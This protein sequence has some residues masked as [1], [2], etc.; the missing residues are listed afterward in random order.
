LE[1]VEGLRARGIWKL[2]KVKKLTTFLSRTRGPTTRFTENQHKEVYVMKKLLIVLAAILIH[3]L[4][5]S[6][7]APAQRGG[8]QRGGGWGPGSSYER[9]YNPQTVETISGVVVS[10]DKFTPIKGMSNGVHAAVKTDKETIS[11]HL[12]PAWFLDNQDAK[13]RQGDRVE[14]KGSR[15]TFE[16]KPAIIAAEV[17]K[18]GETLTLRDASGVPVWSGWRRR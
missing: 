15:I 4:V 18:D 2:R 9:L 7:E 14:I 6:S 1:G 11:V 10:V 13:I 16:G 8:M 3:S 12:G 5:F 17:T